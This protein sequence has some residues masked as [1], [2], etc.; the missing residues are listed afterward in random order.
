MNEYHIIYTQPHT[1][2]NFINQNPEGTDELPEDD[3]QL[4]KHIGTAK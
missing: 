3:T 4:P 1:T 2:Q